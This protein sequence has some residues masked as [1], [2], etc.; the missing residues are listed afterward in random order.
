MPQVSARLAAVTRGAL[1][2]TVAAMPFS[3]ALTQTALAVAILTWLARMAL[4]RRLLVRRTRLE[5]AFLLYMAAELI[6]LAFSIN[7][8]NAVIYLK[9]LLLIPTVYVVASN[10]ESERTLNRLVATFLAAMSLYSLWGIGSFALNPSLRVRHIQ[11]S[12]TAGGLT[13]IAAVVGLALAAASTSKKVR[14]WAGASAVVNATCLFFTNTRGSWLGFA[15]AL[16]LMAVLTNWRL[17]LVIPVLA[18]VAYVAVPGEYKARVT[19]FFD[20]HYRTNA[21][22]LTWWKTGWRIFKD[23]PITGVGDIDTV[24]IYRRYLSPEETQAVGHFHNNFVHIAV[25]LGSIG[26]VA[27]SYLKARIAIF[28][29][30]TLR[31]ARPPSLRAVALAG[32]CSFVAF[33][34]NGL[35]EWNYGDAEVVTVIWWLVGM[36]AATATLLK[37]SQALE[38]VVVEVLS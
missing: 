23:Y 36:V 7:V 13:M 17:L 30:Q 5:V 15:V 22:R 16:V 34:V 33:L 8:P 2:V 10:V 28:M 12:M 9:R 3:I 35:F 20:P 4:E 32:L 11:N 14:L 1:Y 29:G 21:Y 38:T 26:L 19:H 27:F 31:V 25:T 6:S 18:V 24:E 37:R